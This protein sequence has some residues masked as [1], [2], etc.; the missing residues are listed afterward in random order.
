M[1]TSPSHV[2]LKSSNPAVAATRGTGVAAAF[3]APPCTADTLPTREHQ[4]QLHAHHARRHDWDDADA[5][6]TDIWRV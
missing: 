4:R 5:L 6:E 1:R 3:G 2:G